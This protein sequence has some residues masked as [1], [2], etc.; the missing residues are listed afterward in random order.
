MGGGP[1]RRAFPGRLSNTVGGQVS[2]G[3][4]LEDKSPCVL[5]ALERASPLIQQFPSQ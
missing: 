5:K 1:L 3:I 4:F 2:Q